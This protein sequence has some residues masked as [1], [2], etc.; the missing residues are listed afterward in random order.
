VIKQAKLS[1]D[2]FVGKAA[3]DFI[4]NHDL[5][6]KPIKVQ[7]VF[8]S[9]GMPNFKDKANIEKCLVDLKKEGTYVHTLLLTMTDMLV[10]SRNLLASQADK[11]QFLESKE[12]RDAARP[13]LVE[14]YS[15]NDIITNLAACTDPYKPEVLAGTIQPSADGRIELRL[16]KDLNDE[17]GKPVFRKNASLFSVFHKLREKFASF[18]VNF[19]PLDAQAAFKIFSSE[20]IPNKE[21]AVIFS[22]EGSD[23]AWDIATMSMRGIKSCQR[24]DGEY[25][26]CLIGSI[27]SKFVGVIYLTSGIQAEANGG[28]SN[29]G[30]KMMRRCVIRYAIDAD[31][32]KPCILIDKMYPDL[33]KDVLSVFINAIKSRTEL[34]VYYT[35]ELGNKIRH[36]YIPAEE[37]RDKIIDREWSYQDTP[38]KS[39][40]DLNISALNINKEEVER[41][42]RGFK[43]NLA[44]FIARRMEEV[45]SGAK[46]IDPEFKRIIS[47]IKMNISYT[48]FCEQLST[49]ILTAYRAPVSVTYTDSKIYYRKYLM[50]LLKNRAKILI[51]CLPNLQTL[52]ANNMSRPLDA[53]KFTE[54]LFSIVIEFTRLEIKKTI[55]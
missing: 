35:A 45:A 52:F 3:P 42:I 47:N 28:Y 9:I 23:G 55:S 12:A 16:I 13:K 11:I 50:D 25:P 38:L 33:D 40:H 46:S 51:T 5:F 31:E 43:I 39:K 20:N 36:I 29:L 14:L 24:W 49:F 44:L 30:T 10:N 17:A 37:M 22:A 8:R 32:D 6:R 21:F 41:E 19:G 54:Y 7:K 2:L 53:T 18:N 34:A 27:L 26:R 48:P 4:K 1:T 15:Y